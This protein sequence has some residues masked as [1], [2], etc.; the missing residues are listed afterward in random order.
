MKVYADHSATTP[1]DKGVLE[2]MEPF[3]SEKYGNASSLHSFGMEARKEVEEARRKVA[4]VINADPKEIVFTS[5]GTESNNIAIKGIALSKGKGHI[6]TSS[7]E[8]KCV[9]EN[10]KWLEKQGFEVTF[11]GVDKYG[12]VDPKE[13]EKAMRDDTILVTVMHGNNEI[14][15]INDIAAIGKICREKEVA[16]HTDV[17]QS[18]TK[19]PVDVVS[20]KIDMLSI[21]SHK[22]HGPKGVGALYVKKGIK[23]EPIIHGGGHE[24]GMR[25]GT[26]NVSGIVGFGE[27]IRL[28]ESEREEVMPRLQKLRDRIVDGL[29]D[30]ENSWL[31]AH[32]DKRLPHNAHFCF[33]NIEGEALVM[34]LDME[35]VAGSTG[36]ACS[37]KKLEPSH[38]LL[39]I[40]LKPEDAHGSL[41][42]TLGKQNTGEDADYII[43]SVKKVV[44]D[45][46]KMSPF[47]GA[48]R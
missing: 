22:I 36:S 19:I 42:I 11:L 39:A 38:V 21:S 35:G 28:A 30:V 29:K 23:L 27:A 34:K 14:G 3:F 45:L 18:V 32:P 13:V 43:K 16:F 31:N 17:V 24:R 33:K 7:I 8:H 44:E 25:S 4:E 10:C 20:M 48:V 47:K 26:E 12:A 15:T 40:G 1:V 46:R 41:R 2:F 5:G 6:I 37:S 9:V